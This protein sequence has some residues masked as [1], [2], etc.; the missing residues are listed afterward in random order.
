MVHGWFAAT[1]RSAR[2]ARTRELVTSISDRTSPLAR[3]IDVFAW[4]VVLILV[5]ILPALTSGESVEFSLAG[6]DVNLRF[7]VYAAAAAVLAMLAVTVRWRQRGRDLRPLVPIL[8]FF[9]WL[10]LVTL[11]A[12]QPPREFLPLL[13]RWTLSIAAFAIATEVART[14]VPRR[15]REAFLVA[16]G[17][18]VAI[19]LI[20]GLLELVTGTAP[21]LNGAPR[22]SGSLVGHPVAFSLVLMVAAVLLLPVTL[23]GRRPRAARLV[24]AAIV[25]LATIEIL[26]TYTRL[27]LALL[28]ACAVVVV[29][30]ISPVH[31][32]RNGGI[33]GLA[34]IVILVVAAPLIISR[35]EQPVG[36]LPLPS[37]IPGQP[38]ATPAPTPTARLVLIDNS[39]K[40]RI[41]THELGVGYIASSPIIGHGAGSF[42]RLFGSDTG[43]PNVAAHDDFLLYAVEAGLPGLGLLL[44]AYALLLLPLVGWVFD[45]RADGGFAIAALVAFGAVNIGAV[46]HN[47]TYFPEIQVTV[48]TAVGLASQPAVRA[49]RS[50]LGRVRP[51]RL[52]EPSAS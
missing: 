47:P 30:A 16:V 29:V 20:W 4:S 3:P 17:I 40:L 37:T 35:F 25:A 11:I 48:W 2:H 10:C 18:G 31:R 39:T 49:L 52:P 42:D 23:D 21:T 8:A 13:L 41:R 7:V 28:L 34:S 19:P 5:A 44:I 33:A 9:G 1:L 50:R 26:F 36:P 27:T 32:L 45:A 43:M 22:L 24:A 12:R 46:I 14:G 51:Q 15:A 6:Q 38:N